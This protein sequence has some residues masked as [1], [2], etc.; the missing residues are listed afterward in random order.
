MKL[1]K[2]LQFKQT[3]LANLLFIVCVLLLLGCSSVTSA[4]TDGQPPTP[5]NV[6][7]AW[8][9]TIEYSGF[10]MAEEKGYFADENLAVTLNTYDFDKP[11]DPISQ[12]VEGKA[13]FGTASAGAVLSARAEGKPVV[14]VATIYQ[15][16]PSVLISL[17][18]KNITRPQD[19][20]GKKVLIDT[21]SPDSVVYTAMIA[22]QKD[23]DL[24]QVKIVP[25]TDFSNDPLIKGEVDVMDAFI[26]N[27]PVQLEKEGYKINILIPAN[28]GVDMYA[29]VIITSEEMIAQNPDLVERFVRAIVRGIQSAIDDPKGATTLTVARN[30]EINFESE[31][32]S[33]NRSL[34]LFNPAGSRP[35]SMTPEIWASVHQ[36][37][38]ERG[39]LKESLEVEKAYTLTFLDKVSS[40]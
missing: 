10:Y 5:V 28:Y 15:R 30:K 12:V 14:A 1:T 16:N 19:L 35:G 26:N 32:E 25:R 40:K 29:N 24:A 37:M 23:L 8:I 33:M 11:L 13:Q 39:L 36:M 18:E 20:V 4:A 22:S 21:S 2:P 3:I 34:P 31:L 38:L 27:Q 17:A 9:H 7:L 6:Q